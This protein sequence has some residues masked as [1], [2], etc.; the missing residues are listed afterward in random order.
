M[1]I[2]AAAIDP[3]AIEARARTSGLG[4]VVTFL[5]VVRDTDERGHAVAALEYEAYES[6]ALA[7]FDTI[8]SEVTAR[9]GNVRLAIA[10]RVGRV[11]PGEVS[12][13]VCA[14]AVHRKAAFSACEYAIDAVKERAP[15][16]K[17]EVY[18]DG[19]ATWKANQPRA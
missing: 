14:A 4:G 17:R 10:H 19:S 18:A 9:F 5:G 8:A 6:L 15:I 16:W 7:E 13:V 3:R 12:V 1:S 11:A 2:D